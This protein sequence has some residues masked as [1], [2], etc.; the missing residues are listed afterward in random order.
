LKHSIFRLLKTNEHGIMAVLAVFVGLAGGF[1]AVG[2]RYL[3]NFF[4]SI[5]YGSDG[6]LLDI[7]S[8]ISW[9]LRIL[10]PTLGGL[11]VGPL[12]YFRAREAKGHGVPEVM[13]AVALKSGLI[14]K[15]L[16]VIK[17][18]ASAICIGTGG[19]VGREGPIVQ[20]GSAIGSTGPAFVLVCVSYIYNTYRE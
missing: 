6:N 1:G 13:E 5:A 17:S 20:I 4:Q 15:R 3:I 14:R 12:V 7:V 19:S 10:I 8:S 16:V 18:L 2:F 9:Y 11:V